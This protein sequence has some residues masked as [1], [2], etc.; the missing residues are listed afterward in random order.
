MY[1]MGVSFLEGTL[2]GVGVKGNQKITLS[3]GVPKNWT[4]MSAIANV[5]ADLAGVSVHWAKPQDLSSRPERTGTK[6]PRSLLP[7]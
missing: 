1:N 3:C 5:E 6:N 2:F 7:L 4:P